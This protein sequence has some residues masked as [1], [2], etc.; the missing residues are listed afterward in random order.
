[1]N[2]DMDALPHHCLGHIYALIHVCTKHAFH[3]HYAHKHHACVF[4]QGLS[5]YVATVAA[6]KLS[7]QLLQFVDDDLLEHQFGVSDAGHRNN[8]LELFEK[9]SGL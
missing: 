5:E 1:M 7:G 6:S 2:E 4:A 3:I 9:L 8:I